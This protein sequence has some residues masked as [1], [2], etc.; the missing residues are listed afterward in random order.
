VNVIDW[1]YRTEYYNER[2]ENISVLV[3]HDTVTGSAEDTLNL[4]N[5][6]GLSVHYIAGR[7]GTIYR[8]VND[9]KRAY[10][11]GV[12]DW[13]PLHNLN[14]YSVGIEIVNWG[15]EPFPDVQVNKNK[16]LVFIML[17]FC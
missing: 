5:K 12:S 2:Y 8:M 10:H 17:K 7:N 1:T 3:L 9:S 16:F 6:E 4:L 13:G 11:A 14:N 15:D